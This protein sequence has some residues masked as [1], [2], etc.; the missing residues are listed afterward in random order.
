MDPSVIAFVVDGPIERADIPGLCDRFRA[1]LA[2][3]P[4]GRVVCRVGPLCSLDA[5]TVEALVRLKLTARRLGRQFVLIEVADDL[6][7]LVGFMGLRPVLLASLDQASRRGG[8]P[9]SGKRASVSRKKV[10]PA[11]RPPDSSST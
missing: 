4:P 6:R 2:D 11:T 1:V 5:V 3:A 9:N 8:R 7:D 10:I